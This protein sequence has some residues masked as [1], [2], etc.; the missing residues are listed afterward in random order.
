MA[1]VLEGA[2]PAFLGKVMRPG[3]HPRWVSRFGKFRCAVVLQSFGG[4]MPIRYRATIQYVYGYQYVHGYHTL[5]W[6]ASR[7][8]PQAAVDNAVK[9]VQRLFDDLGAFL[10]VNADGTF[11]FKSNKKGKVQRA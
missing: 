7:K 10:S 2:P 11:K 3:D 9:R 8:K 1:T 4:H 5:A 6:G